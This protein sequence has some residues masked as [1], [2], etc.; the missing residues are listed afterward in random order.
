[1]FSG[2]QTFYQL[3][4][5]AAGSLIG[6]LFIVATL[7]SGQEQPA[8]GIGVKL[9]TTPTVFHLSL[10]LIVSALALAP[11][12]EIYSASLVMALC[13]FVGSGYALV[14]AVRIRGLSN[15]THWSDFWCYGVAPV[16]VYLALAAAAGAACWRAPHA[17]YAVGMVLLALLMVAI[18]NAWDLITWLAPRR[19]D[20]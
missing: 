16:A 7:S 5:S 14:I 18:R 12:T 20:G 13:A 9:F 11:G 17:A 10:V 1:M 6:L 8:V 19:R 15:P 2:W 4:G 3:T